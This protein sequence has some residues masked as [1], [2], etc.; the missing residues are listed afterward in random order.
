MH[1]I[2]KPNR[3]RQ[4]PRR[5]CTCPTTSSELWYGHYR[6]PQ[7]SR[8]D[9]E[10]ARY[11]C[12]DLSDLDEIEVEAELQAIVGTL[13]VL[14]AGAHPRAREWLLDRRRR[15]R[16]RQQTPM[17]APPEEGVP[18]MSEG[19]PRERAVVVEVE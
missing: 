9:R 10:F 14:P 15:L 4:P 12:R 17:I 18:A 6:V 13:A 16:G 3:P 7:P 1:A 5:S 8:C 2:Q 19:V 11:H